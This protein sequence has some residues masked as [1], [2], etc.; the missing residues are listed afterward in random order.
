MKAEQHK[1]LYR[2]HRLTGLFLMLALLALIV[3]ALP[4][5]FIDQLEVW[6]LH[7][8][9]ISSQPVDVWLQMASESFALQEGSSYLQFFDNGKPSILWV[10]QGDEFAPW[11]L[12]EGLRFEPLVFLDALH[13]LEHAHYNFLIPGSV[14]L[15]VVGAVGLLALFSVLL[16]V[17]LHQKWRSEATQLRRHK[18]SRV[19]YSDLHKL[20]GLWLLPFNLLVTYTG[21]VLGLGGLLIIVAALTAFEGDQDKAVAAILGEKPALEKQYCESVSIDG[22]VAVANE[23]WQQKLGGANLVNME[24]YGFGDCAGRVTISHKVANPLVDVN[25]L[26]FDL[27]DGAQVNEKNWLETG[28]GSRWYSALVP[29]HFGSFSGVWGQWLYFI[30][31]IMMGG[32]LL[33]G[34][35][36]Y[37][38]KLAEQNFIR[39][40][41]WLGVSRGLVLAISSN[42]LLFLL[43]AKLQLD[44]QEEHYLA[45]YLLLLVLL[46]GLVVFLGRPLERLLLVLQVFMAL[47]LALFDAMFL[48]L[49]QWPVIL[50]FVM[51]AM[52]PLVVIF[53]G[54]R[55]AV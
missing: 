52:L 4:L 32:M 19:F 6:L 13:V 41:L 44:W 25:T 2:W 47:F 14:G 26:T 8:L 21:A 51:V 40:R 29:L 5:L 7:G 10:K 1:K 37:I 18:S 38:D 33:S 20:L 30:L 31:A 11:T 23:H 50:S 36:L 42:S 43:L 16:G 34:L 54:W 22:L 3:T 27:V 53:S 39:K 35:Y 12:L 9:P 15:Y 17:I 55:R 46:P 24:L 49:W 45:A 48:A 28:V